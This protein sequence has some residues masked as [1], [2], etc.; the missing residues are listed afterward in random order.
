MR[1]V[2][3]MLLVLW[4]GCGP[5]L[6]GK[7]T[8][9]IGTGAK[10]EAQGIYRAEFDA[11]TGTLTVPQKAADLPGA[12]YL[13]LDRGQGRLFATTAVKGED[14]MMT[15]GVAAFY[16]EDGK[17]ISKGVKSAQGIGTCHVG[18]DAEGRVLVAANYGD[19]SAASFHITQTGELEGPV[20]FHRHEGF[21]PDEKRQEGPHAHC[22]VVLPGNGFVG[23]CDLGIDA[24]V[25]YR[26]DPGTGKLNPHGRAV[27]PAGAG[28]R[29]LAVHP[30]GTWVYVVN[31]LEPSVTA[32]AWDAGR[33]ELQALGTWSA[34]KEREKPG[35]MEGFTA[36]E[37][38]VHP[39]GKYVVCAVR[40]VSKEG[41]RDFLSVFRV[42]GEGRLEC[43]ENEPARVAV[44][45]NF[46]F[47]PGG[48]WLLAGGQK[49]DDVQVFRFD[50]G[51]GAL[52]P[53]G[54]PVG[55][56]VPMCFVFE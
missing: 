42:D 26:V 31:E 41:G 7:T 17:L 29:H 39:S 52:E 38:R 6:T 11:E 40:E 46:A 32:F 4:A 22:A 55:V 37:I 8:V 27:L 12:G 49:S 3:G 9:W 15:G 34:W 35:S 44:P 13:A 1:T 25:V 5:S 14:G 53:H 36:S 28:P 51:T 2:A 33:G 23:V 18:L 43:V 50:V 24:V 21:G 19:G 10:G 47:H 16:I 20:S 30:G 48:K 54:E 45:R 56:P